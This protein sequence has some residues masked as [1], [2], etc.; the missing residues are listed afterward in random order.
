MAMRF[1]DLHAHNHAKSYL[2]LRPNREKHRAK[3]EYHPWTI[4]SDHRKALQKGDMGSR[5]AQADLVKLWNG[6]VRLAFNALYPIERGF[7]TISMDGIAGED[8]WYK[9]LTRA[10]TSQHLPLRDALQFMVMF[11][12]DRM[13]DHFQS[14]GYDYWAA[15]K[16]EYAYAVSKDGQPTRNNIHTPTLLRQLLESEKRRRR[17]YPRELDALGT[18]A[19]PRTRAELDAALYADRIA[20]VLT[21]EGAHSFGTDR[22]SIDACLQRVMEVKRWPHPVF[23]ITFAHH[24]DNG[25][26]GHA[27]SFPDVSTFIMDQGPRLNEGFTP[28]GWRMIRRL[29]SLR[30]DN[31][32]DPHAGHRIL[33]DV[34]HMSARARKQY[35]ANIVEPRRAMGDVIPVIASHVGY[36]GVATLDRLIAGLGTEKDDAFDASGR[37]NRWNIN[38]CDEDVRIIHRTRGLLGLSFDQRI[39]GVPKAQKTPGGRN[40]IVALWDNVKEMMNVI[41]NDA[42]IPAALRPSIWERITLGS[43]FEGWIDP[44]DDYPTSLYYDAF[45]DHLIQCADA[46]RVSAAP[47]PCLRGFASRAALVHAIDGLCHRNAET[48][49]KDHFPR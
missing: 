15:L 44:I 41:Y 42:T 43:D 37:F 38:V 22:A 27:H 35:Y 47:P 3:G 30:D 39:L 17:R 21:I 13:I 24:F 9:A 31:T 25:L 5:Y 46:E 4:I 7:F 36:S 33:I 32:P 48:F 40:T 34:K 20:M 23:F 10:I 1:A 16:E 26:C 45:R 18:Y 28:G 14:D 29:L 49:V 11:I 2:W 19:V 12:P 6:G 8:R